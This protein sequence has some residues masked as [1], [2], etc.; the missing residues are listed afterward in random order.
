MG[1]GMDMDSWSLELGPPL[2]L[3]TAP[4][5]L[6]ISSI[7]AAEKLVS[8]KKHCK[9]LRLVNPATSVLFLSFFLLRVAIVY[10]Y[11][12]LLIRWC[13]HNEGEEDKRIRR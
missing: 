8:S 4:A 10:K 9:E 11:C 7:F 12:L 5:C 6:P 3:L 1:M 2:W 13:C